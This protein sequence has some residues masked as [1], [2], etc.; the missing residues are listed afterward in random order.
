MKAGKANG[1][2]QIAGFQANHRLIHEYIKGEEM[3]A[4]RAKG[5]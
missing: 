3:S 1:Q 4:G 5:Q 2:E